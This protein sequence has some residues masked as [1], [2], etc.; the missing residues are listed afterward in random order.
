MSAQ[1]RKPLA[2]FIGLAFAAAVMVGVHRADAQTGH[3]LASVMGSTERV[4]G[5]LPELSASRSRPSGEQ[6]DRLQPGFG[7]IVAH[8]QRDREQAAAQPRPEAGDRSPSAPSRGGAVRAGH[9]VVATPAEVLA[10]AERKSA[11]ERRRLLYADRANRGSGERPDIERSVPRNEKALGPRA[12]ARGHV[13]GWFRGHASDQGRRG[14][15]GDG[16]R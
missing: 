12:S 6:V 13:R 9:Q 10:G 1:H 14:A 15:V 3:F 8:E 7:A 2:A 16:R 11:E 4:H 5:L